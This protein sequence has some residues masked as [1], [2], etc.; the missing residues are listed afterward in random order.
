MASADYSRGKMD[1]SDQSRTWSGFL[2]FA[3]WGSFITILSVAYMT[4]TLAMGMNWLI[5]LVLCA[6]F[7]IVGGLLLGMGGAW[8]AAVIGLSALAVFVQVLIMISRALI[9]S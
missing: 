6:G 4:F 2:K 7:G 9:A 3:L 8:I 1:I 5:A